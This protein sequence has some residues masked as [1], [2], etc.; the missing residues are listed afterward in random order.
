MEKTF[1]KTR[2]NMSNLNGPHVEEFLNE[3]VLL[4]TDNSLHILINL[5]FNVSLGKKAKYG[6]IFTC[7][8]T[9]TVMYVTLMS[10]S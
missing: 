4:I 8:S 2:Q 9:C 10:S 6:K 5:E 7:R 1:K 3:S